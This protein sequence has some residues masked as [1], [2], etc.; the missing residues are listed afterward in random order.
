MNFLEFQGG[1]ERVRTLIVGMQFQDFSVHDKELLLLFYANRSFILRLSLKTPPVFFLEDENFKLEK[2]SQKVPLAL[3]LSKHFLRK[4][5]VDVK[6]LEEWGRKFEI[7]F[8]DE[9]QNPLVIEIVLV[10]GFQNVGLFVKDEAKGKQVY[11][12]KPRE[13]SEF[14]SDSKA[15]VAEFR[16]LDIIREEW[17]ADLKLD[18]K[19]RVEKNDSPVAD[20]SWKIEIRKKIKKKSEAIEKIKQQSNENESVIERLYA[21][22]EQLKYNSIS[23]LSLDDQAWIK[24]NQSKNTDRE[25]IFKKAK[26]LAAKKDGMSSRITV[27][28]EEIQTLTRALDLGPPQPKHKISIAGKEDVDTRKLEISPSLS[29]YMG[30]NAKDNVQLLKN[31]QPW[32]F[33]FHLK[34][35]PSAYAI[36]RKNKATAVGHADL[37]KMATWFAREC[38][39]NHKEKAPAHIEVIYTEC[40]FVKLLKGDKLGRVTHTNTKTLRVSTT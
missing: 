6:Y 15:D 13:L 1:V 5:V 26:T 18:S 9:A 28:L 32:E 31:S 36:T 11:W 12:N 29:V 25:Q 37:I 35:Y 22:G 8:T 27:L 33:W 38:F 39:K 24:Q 3:F 34:D 23:Q 14:T 17:Y 10:P 4:K 7:H 40:R 21:I 20:D 19:Q 16:S 2:K 30:K